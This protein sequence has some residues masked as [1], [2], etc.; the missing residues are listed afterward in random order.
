MHA[1]KS[2]VTEGLAIAEFRGLT[3]ALPASSKGWTVGNTTRSEE[4]GQ[5]IR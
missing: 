5:K 3:P 2:L 4:L 1:F